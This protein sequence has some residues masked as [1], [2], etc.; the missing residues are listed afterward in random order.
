ML[1]FHLEVFHWNKNGTLKP[2][3]LRHRS[4]TW[5]SSVVTSEVSVFASFLSEFLQAY[6][7]YMYE[8]Y[9]KFYHVHPEIG[10]A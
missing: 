7:Y 8:K 4:E 2:K 6:I 5:S 10:V 3:E 9:F 1:D